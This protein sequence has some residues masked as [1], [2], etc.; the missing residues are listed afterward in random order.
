MTNLDSSKPKE[1]ADYNIKFD[2]DGGKFYKTGQ[3]GKNC[4][5]RAIPPFPPTFSKKLV[6]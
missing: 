3:K 4:S 2:E 1:F 5:L 6:L